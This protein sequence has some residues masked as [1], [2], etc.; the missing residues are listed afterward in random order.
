[1]HDNKNAIV[2]AQIVDQILSSEALKEIK[3]KREE[4]VNDVTRDRRILHDHS[5][6]QI[7]GKSIDQL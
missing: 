2:E 7:V 4:Q 1:M 3:D 6:N 5:N